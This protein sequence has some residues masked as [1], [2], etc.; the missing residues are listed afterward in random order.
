MK[1][2]IPTQ[3][4]K[5]IMK[6]KGFPESTDKRILLAKATNNR[7]A[8]IRIGEVYNLI[9]LADSD[10]LK[11]L[12]SAIRNERKLESRKHHEEIGGII[13]MIISRIFQEEE[14]IKEARK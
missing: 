1:E 11:S 7:I 13:K 12:I 10:E 14:E 6:L 3:A 8:D 2:N 9:P 4:L 5:D